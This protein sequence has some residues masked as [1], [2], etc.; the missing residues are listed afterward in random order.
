M[1]ALWILVTFGVVAGCGM[2]TAPGTDAASPGTDAASTTDAGPDAQLPDGGDPCAALTACC[3]HVTV[4]EY[5]PFCEST[6][7]S[8]DRSRC[9]SLL[10]DPSYCP[11]H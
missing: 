2:A 3:P 10:S 4:P 1:R 5:R 7:A 11:P 8:G 9:A 6:A